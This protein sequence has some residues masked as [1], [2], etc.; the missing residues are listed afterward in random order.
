FYSDDTSTPSCSTLSLPDALPISVVFDDLVCQLGH[1][2]LHSERPGR[3]DLVRI[4]RRACSPLNLRYPEFGAFRPP[5]RKS[6]RGEGRKRPASRNTVQR[7]ATSMVA[8]NGIVK[9]TCRR[10]RTLASS[11]APWW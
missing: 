11:S 3:C 1:E 10:L 7:T 8:A 6:L 2:S 5:G 9:C 4:D